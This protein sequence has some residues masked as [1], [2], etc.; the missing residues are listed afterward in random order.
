MRITFLNS[1]Y[2]PHGGAGAENT[3]RLL[4]RSFATAGH[5]CD[6]VTLTPRE[7]SEAGEIDGVPVQYLPLA[8]V[9][10][11]HGGSRT[12][13]LRPVFQAI[14]AYN[15]VMEAR[16]RR[17]LAA[18]RPDVLNCHNLQ[19]FS[20]SAWRAAERLDI[21]VVQTLHDYYTACPRSAMWRPKT[22]NCAGLCAECRIF[23]APRRALSAIPAAATCVSHRLFDRLVAAGAFPRARD[24][25]QP[26]R[27]IRGNNA[28]AATQSPAPQRDGLT[29]GF[30]GRIE[31][32]KGLDT[33]IEAI[34]DLAPGALTLL[35]AGKADE[36]HARAL[37]E[38][39]ATRT[40]VR[41]AGYVRPQDFFPAIDCLVIPSC[42]ED[43]FPRVFHEALG[44]GV[45]SLVTPLGGLPEVIE[46]GR[47][48]FVARGTDAAA[49]RDA[50]AALLSP[51]WDRAAMREACLA[52][53]ADYAPERIF[54][55]YEAVMHAAATRSA[56]PEDAG[57]VWRPPDQSARRAT[58]VLEHASHGA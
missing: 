42:W 27:I 39:V 48:G 5:E 8:N 38:S 29:L 12:A 28:D 4:V 51:T 21:P 52:A 31:P 37:R 55:Q 26:V 49:L 16:L 56:V 15:P 50:V 22:G 44:F 47:N 43:P 19:G 18:R 14:E 34:R 10:W 35:I 2:P 46:P 17:V 1:L 53:A 3:L 25:G 58:A 7:R 32:S 54:A 20:A 9:Y 6:V 41:F 57:E 40:D 45:P 30:M 13:A 24:G 11:P 33:L 23:A 36:G